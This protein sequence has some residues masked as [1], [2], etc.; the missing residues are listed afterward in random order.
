MGGTGK[1]KKANLKMTYTKISCLLIGFFILNKCLGQSYAEAMKFP[2][3]KG[4]EIRAPPVTMTL[5][6]NTNIILEAGGIYQDVLHELDKH[7]VYLKSGEEKIK[8]NAIEF[9]AGQVYT[10]QVVLKPSE[11]L[12][13]GK[14]YKLYIDDYDSTAIFKRN[15][16]GKSETP[17]SWLVIAKTDTVKPE[18]LLKPVLLGKNSYQP[19]CNNSDPFYACHNFECV[20]F[21]C[22]IKSN[23]NYSVKTTI[24]NTATHKR[25]I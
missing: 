1:I 13:V 14:N 21:E 12:I 22:R 8:L 6:Q 2:A 18:W 9:L 17:A 10:T 5:Q 15:V 3:C 25:C 20:S 7:A 23:A 19:Q 11:K 24:E 4:F 16:A